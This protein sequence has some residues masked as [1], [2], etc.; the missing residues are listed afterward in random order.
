VTP[1]QREALRAD[2]QQD[3]IDAFGISNTIQR[4]FGRAKLAPV[5]F[6]A[7]Y[8]DEALLAVRIREHWHR[9]YSAGYVPLASD[10]DTPLVDDELPR[11]LSTSSFAATEVGKK[12][13]AHLAVAQLRRAG[14]LQR[15]DTE[16]AELARPLED[17]L[18]R[19]LE[20]ATGLGMA[21]MTQADRFEQARRLTR[22]DADEA[23]TIRIPV[24][25]LDSVIAFAKLR[26]ELGRD[27]APKELAAAT[28][29]ELERVEKVWDT[30]VEY[31]RDYRPPPVDDAG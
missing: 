22:A 5:E 3:Q 21:T 6:A 15:L 9:V 31:G 13:A 10:P 23:A 25:L 11:L 16:F 2:L 27:P 26:G 29:K 12:L 24:H 8:G 1:D 19:W 14:E 20:E 18:D 4:L 7:T 28:G 17:E 30:L